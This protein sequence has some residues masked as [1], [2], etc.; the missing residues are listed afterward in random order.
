[1]HLEM[2]STK[3]LVKRPEKVENIDGLVLPENFQKVPTRGEVI[4]VGPGK[5]LS[6]GSI[7][8]MTVKVGDTIIFNEY[9]GNT[10]EENLLKD[11]NLIVLDD[12]DDVLA[13]VRA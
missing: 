6:N 12:E 3:I 10:L 4:A 2:V 13:I 9:A 5:T 1:M 7:A 11:T 8:K